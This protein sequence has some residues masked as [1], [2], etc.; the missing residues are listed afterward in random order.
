MVGGGG[1]QAPSSLGN[2]FPLAAGRAWWGGTGWPWPAAGAL[3][4]LGGA[5]GR[6]CT[7][8]GAASN[9]GEVIL[10]LSIVLTINR[11]GHDPARP[12]GDTVIA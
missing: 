4:V 6:M 9:G 12:L 11:F 5:G 7:L 2:I 3:L 10:L 1:R 8:G